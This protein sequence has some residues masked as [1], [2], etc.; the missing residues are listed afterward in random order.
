MRV[1]EVQASGLLSTAREL[2]EAEGFQRLSCLTAVD[3]GEGLEAVYIL[4]KPAEREQ[5]TLKVPLAYEGPVVESLTSLWPGADWLEREVYDLFGIGFEGH[6]DLRRIVLEDDFVGH[7]LL[8][9][10]EHAPGTGAD[11]WRDGPRVAGGAPTGTGEDVEQS[12]GE[13]FLARMEPTTRMRTEKIVLNMGPQHPST[14]GVLH[15]LLLLEGEVVIAAEPSIGYLHRSIEKLCESRSYKQCISLMDRADYVS[16]FHTEL[17]FLLA[18][19]RLGGIEVPPKAQYLRVL[20]SEL[21]RISSHL[22]WLSAYGLDLGAITPLL[23]CFRERE[24]IVDLFEAAS[25]AR[26]MFNYFRVGGVKDDLPP[27]LAG[28]IETF[29]RGFDKAVDEYEALLTG[30]EIFLERTQGTGVASADLMEGYCVTGP[31][32]RASGV[33]ADLRVDEPYSGYE[34]FDV[35]VAVGEVGDCFDR[36]TVRLAEMREAARLALAA[37]DGMPEGEHRGEAPKIFK[38]PAGE[39]YARVEG[40]RGELGVYLVSDGTANP[41]RAKIRSPALSNLSV[42][43]AMLEGTRLADLIAIVG[44]VDVVMGEIDR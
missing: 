22:V 3:T 41:W 18:A 20:F 39:T 9:S 35:R 33:A 11:A 21:C 34:H 23:Y 38:P 16:G 15:V 37:L 7:P 29:L 30:N 5:L 8:K 28:E 4:E 2:K 25:G 31:A 1:R 14:H 42:L 32:L 43:P 13:E 40:P 19:E 26:M 10:Y 36:Y 6:P 17:A 44:A 12:L 27:G 24:A